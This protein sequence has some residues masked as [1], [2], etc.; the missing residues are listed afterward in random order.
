M[1][2]KVITDRLFMAAFSALINTTFQP[3]TSPNYL[4]I[5]VCQTKTT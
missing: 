2:L 4:L 3:K 5:K 1:F